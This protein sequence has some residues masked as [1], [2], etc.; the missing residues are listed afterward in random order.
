MEISRNFYRPHHIMIWIGIVCS[1]P[2]RCK[3]RNIIL[4]TDTKL[5]KQSVHLEQFESKM[6]QTL[7]SQRLVVLKHIEVPFIK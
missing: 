7:L 6:D 2:N 1:F 3:Q 5:L 4:I